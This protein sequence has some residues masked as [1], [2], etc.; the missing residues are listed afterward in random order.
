[1]C[2]DLPTNLSHVIVDVAQPKARIYLQIERA[3]KLC[4]MTSNKPRMHVPR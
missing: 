1:M 3:S 4:E 2:L